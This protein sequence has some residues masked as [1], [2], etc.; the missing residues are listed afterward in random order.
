MRI[1]QHIQERPVFGSA[2]TILRWGSTSGGK[3]HGK[4]LTNQA[5]RHLFDRDP[6]GPPF[7]VTLCP[8][9]ELP[10]DVQPE[11]LD[12]D[13]VGSV[14]G[15]RIILGI[16]KGDTV[17][18]KSVAEPGCLLAGIAPLHGLVELMQRGTTRN[19]DAP[20]DG[21]VNAFQFD[22]ELIHI[23]IAETDARAGR[24]SHRHLRVGV[25]RGP[26]KQ[27]QPQGI[28]LTARRKRPLSREA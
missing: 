13:L 14:P 5:W 1:L 15:N 9:Q 8:M 3:A 19:R 26:L 20:P 23:A 24:E 17:D 22:A 21:R 25:V 11:L 16:E 10:S 2:G 27:R 7:P 4:P 6:V 12:R 18:I 28:Q